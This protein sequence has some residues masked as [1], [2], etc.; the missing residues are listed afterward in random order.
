[1]V[2]A[3][4]SLLEWRRAETTV[5]TLSKLPADYYASTTRYLEELRRSYE[6][7]LR[8]NPSARRGEIARQTYQR[9]SQVARDILESRVQKLLTMSFQASIGAPRDL[10]NSLAE[11]K[12]L[13]DRLLLTL[14]EHRH[15]VA[16]YLEPQAPPPAARTAA[17]PPADAPSPAP[18][19]DAPPTAR[20]AAVRPPAPTASPA[21][22]RIVGEPRTIEAGTETIA[23]SPD[24]VVS[25]PAEVAKLLVDAQVAELLR[26]APLGGGQRPP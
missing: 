3:Y 6:S 10:P 18:L 24:D 23:L 4:S 11:E 21:Y 5:R 13:F 16:P 17:P 14:L 25:L 9:A 15:A 12:G 20:P 2:E 26:V 1:M 7:E 22:V 8:E 19:R